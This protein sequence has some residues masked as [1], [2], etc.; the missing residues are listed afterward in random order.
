MENVFPNLPG[1]ASKSVTDP[2]AQQAAYARLRE[3]GADYIVYSDGSAEGGTERGGAGVVVTQGDPAC[4][5]VLETL[6]RKGSDLTSS[7]GEK[8]SA[9]QLGLEWI[10]ENCTAEAKVGIATDSQSLC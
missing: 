1:I 6:R 9:M 5:T 7:Y 3:F 2:V 10:A 8:Q 4:P